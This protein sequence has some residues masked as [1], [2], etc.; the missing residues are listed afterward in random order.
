MSQRAELEDKHTV[1]CLGCN[2]EWVDP[3]KKP[4][5]KYAKRCQNCG[6]TNL[7]NQRLAKKAKGRRSSEHMYNALKLVQVLHDK[8]ES[9]PPG[10][11]VQ[12]DPKA[13]EQVSNAIKAYEESKR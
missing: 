5:Q 2:A 12:L 4:G 7:D 8:P 10:Y 13:Y 11:V 1:V 6:R 9:C 3:E